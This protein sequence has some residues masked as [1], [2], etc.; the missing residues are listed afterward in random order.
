VK[1]KFINLLAAVSVVSYIIVNPRLNI[2]LLGH[3]N[4]FIKY[5]IEER[6]CKDDGF[7]QRILCNAPK[8]LFL[9]MEIIK[10]SRQ[11]ILKYCVTVLMFII[12]K[13]HHRN[14]KVQNSDE[15]IQLNVVY[16]F[17]DEADIEMTKYYSKCRSISEKYNNIDSFLV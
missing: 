9:K 14:T 3:A 17:D 6:N 8:P 5:M 4:E 13:Y 2:C 16:K 15:K 10:I 1:I 11:E 7:I 12:S